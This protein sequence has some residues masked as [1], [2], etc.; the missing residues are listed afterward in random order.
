[1][2]KAVDKGLKD[3]FEATPAGYDNKHF[4]HSENPV[5][6]DHRYPHL[7]R[8]LPNL[9][10]KEGEFVWLKPF[11][12]EEKLKIAIGKRIAE[13]FNISWEVR[14]TKVK[15]GKKKGKKVKRLY[16]LIGDKRIAANLR[17]NGFVPLND[18]PFIAQRGKNKGKE[19][20]I[21]NAQYIHGRA[22]YDSRMPQMDIADYIEKND[23]KEFTERELKIV[24]AIIEGPPKNFRRTTWRG[25]LADGVRGKNLA[26]LDIQMK[27]KKQKKE[28]AKKEPL[29]CP[30]HGVETR[31]E[32]AGFAP[33][34]MHIS[35]LK[36]GDV[37]LSVRHNYDGIYWV[38]KRDPDEDIGIVPWDLERHQRRV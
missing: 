2:E 1:V 37:L 31:L 9:F 22:R 17:I 4:W 26:R 34:V 29:I 13:H 3:F 14:E 32:F 33:R 12:D 20:P 16:Y 36:K 38:V 35:E 30:V 27:T 23:I 6:E 7:H 18:K 25:W 8:G 21:T 19:T 11:V 28:E 5:R 10:M 15:R 24:G